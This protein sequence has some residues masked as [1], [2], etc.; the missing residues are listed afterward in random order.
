MKRPVVR[1]GAF[2]YLVL[3]GVRSSTS[4]SSPAPCELVRSARY[5][6]MSMSFSYTIPV[7]VTHDIAAQVE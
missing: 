7:V 2:D 5:L 1:K 4:S 3:P 6:R